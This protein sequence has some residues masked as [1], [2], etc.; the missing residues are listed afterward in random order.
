MCGSRKSA[1]AQPRNRQRR[2]NTSAGSYH[3]KRIN[4]SHEGAI[5]LKIPEATHPCRT[6]HTDTRET[7]PAG[8]MDSRRSYWSGSVSA[9]GK[10]MASTDTMRYREIG[11]NAPLG[12]QQQ[13]APVSIFNTAK[14]FSAG[15]IT[16]GY[17]AIK[18]DA[19]APIAIALS[20][21]R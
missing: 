14:I 10:S 5:T 6:E 1:E 20:H 9:Y 15:K 16:V 11:T 7:V 2:R 18:E 17:R 12:S 13:K 21:H 19:I 4:A 8:G 3:R